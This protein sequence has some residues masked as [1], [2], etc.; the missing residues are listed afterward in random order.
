MFWSIRKRKYHKNDN[1]N[2]KSLQFH[3]VTFHVTNKTLHKH[4]LEIDVWSLLHSDSG[5][6]RLTRTVD[7]SKA[8]GTN[9][10][11]FLH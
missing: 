4:Q 5:L 2:K 9:T 1:M 7:C 8:A 6:C 3:C 11:Y 10:W